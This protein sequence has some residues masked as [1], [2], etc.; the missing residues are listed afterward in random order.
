MDP[1][2]SN[3]K[4]MA[5]LLFL[6]FSP[7]AAAEINSFLAMRCF[8]FQTSVKL[9]VSIHLSNFLNS[10]ISDTKKTKK[11]PNKGGKKSPED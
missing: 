1:Y 3:S 4:R 2:T 10:F 7:L 6:L 11:G 5:F 8:S 9:S